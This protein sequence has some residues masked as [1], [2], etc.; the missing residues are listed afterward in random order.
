[1]GPGSVA[2]ADPAPAAATDLPSMPGFP[3]IAS[4]VP[5]PTPAPAPVGR[6]EEF[7][8][9]VGLW[10]GAGRGRRSLALLHGESGIGKST[11]LLEVAHRVATMTPV[12]PL[13]S[14]HGALAGLRPALADITCPVLL[15]TSPQDHVVEPVS[16]EL[17]AAAVRGPRRP[18]DAGPRGAPVTRDTCPPADNTSGRRAGN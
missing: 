16:S 13:L 1:M 12:E 4:A 14:L 10:V 11:L 5:V 8:R 7:A 6:E 2:P 3:S 9:L 15:L 18:R 17:V